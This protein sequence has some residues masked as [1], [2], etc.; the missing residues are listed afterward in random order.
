MELLWLCSSLF[1]LHFILPASV[2]KAG[3]M[4][5]NTCVLAVCS[6]SSSSFFCCDQGKGCPASRWSSH[7]LRFHCVLIFS[8]AIFGTQPQCCWSNH[9]IFLFFTS[10]DSFVVWI[11]FIC[12]CRF[13]LDSLVS[14][15]DGNSLST[16]LSWKVQVAWNIHLRFNW[17]DT[18]TSFRP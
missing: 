6:K 2:V 18:F 5:Y 13:A 12:C 16:D 14:S 7:D 9:Q 17:T 8:V 15:S 11:Q 10:D 4:H 3:I 1:L